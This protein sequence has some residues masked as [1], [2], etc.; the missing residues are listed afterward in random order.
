MSSRP[1]I[2]M[3]FSSFRILRGFWR[4]LPFFTNGSNEGK[5]VKSVYIGQAF[6]LYASNVSPTI[7]VTESER[8]FPHISIGGWLHLNCERHIIK[9]IHSHCS[10]RILLAP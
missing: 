5:K 7:R 6:A 8:C 9:F 2:F 4:F 3:R 10:K 1:S